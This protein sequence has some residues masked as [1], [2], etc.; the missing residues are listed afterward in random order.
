VIKLEFSLEELNHI[1]S[2]LG[3]LPFAQSNNVISQIVVQA[4]PQAVA[5]A[6]E[7]EK[8]VEEQ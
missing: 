6:A 4:E 1:L 7:A 5:L 2:L 8:E 3:Q